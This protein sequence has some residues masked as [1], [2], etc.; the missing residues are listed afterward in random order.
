M[1]SNLLNIVGC[2]CRNLS[3]G[4]VV[5]RLSPNVKFGIIFSPVPMKRSGNLA[6]GKLNVIL[7]WVLIIAWP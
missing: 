4:F 5:I 1:R 2:S 3:T 6:K 7:I